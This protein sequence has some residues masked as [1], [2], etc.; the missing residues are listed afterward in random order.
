MDACLIFLD[1]TH[2]QKDLKLP[3]NY[4]A[5]VTLGPKQTKDGLMQGVPLTITSLPSP[6]F[7]KS[8]L[9]GCMRMRKLGH[10]QSVVF[11][12]PQEIKTKIRKLLPEDNNDDGIQVSDILI[13]SIRVGGMERPRRRPAGP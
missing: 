7:T 3:A 5:A 4:Q 8:R 13:W 6:L 9:L 11:C 10:G 2:S 12:V 1:E